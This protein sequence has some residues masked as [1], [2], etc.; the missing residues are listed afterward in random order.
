MSSLLRRSRFFRETIVDP[1]GCSSNREGKGVAQELVGSGEKTN[2][3]SRTWRENK[4]EIST[5]RAVIDFRSPVRRRKSSKLL[6]S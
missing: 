4:A 6:S 5:V 1:G 2:G 3:H